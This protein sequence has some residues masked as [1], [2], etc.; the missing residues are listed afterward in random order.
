[1]K[2]RVSVIIPV[3]NGAGLVARAVDSALAQSLAP[4]EIIVVDDGST[5]DTASVLAGYHGRI[6]R[7][8][9]R[10]G[11]VARARNIG[12][13]ASRG[14]LLAFLDA[15]DIWH[16]HKLARQA[17][18]LR[19]WPQAGLCCCD[20]VVLHGAQG[21]QV[22]HFAG[23]LPQAQVSAARPLL[24]APLAPLL[25]CNFIGTASNVLIRRELARRAGGFD[26][27]LRQA[28]DYDYWLRC[29]LR[30]PFV[31]LPEALLHK[32]THGANLTAQALE[33]AEC[34]E[35]VLQKWQAG[36]LLPAEAAALLPGAL[37]RV[38]Y[39]I[40]RQLALHGRAGAA[41][42]YCVRGWRS[43]PSLSNLRP[44]ARTLARCVLHLIA[45]WRHPGS[46]AWRA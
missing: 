5:D 37:S 14:E 31:L 10:H 38:R 20:Y 3:Y 43:E 29:A 8:H 42:R 40:A 26:P 33:T 41:L 22:S 1:M 17:A 13:A 44:A 25:R 2:P 24:A 19:V 27:R 12:M 32:R 45:A 18:A 46:M 4:L 28:E 15:D 36:G 21:R 7:L 6:R 35:Q 30:A 9:I 11:G 16:P 34:H 23:A 39:R